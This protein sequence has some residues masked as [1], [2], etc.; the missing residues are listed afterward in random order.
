MKK[1]DKSVTLQV[2]KNPHTCDSLEKSVKTTEDTKAFIVAQYRKG[3]K[4]KAITN[5]MI[6]AGVNPV[7][8][9]HVIEKVIHTLRKTM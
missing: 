7:P 3:L 2:A 6:E 8:S 1:E 9:K 4:P 5:A